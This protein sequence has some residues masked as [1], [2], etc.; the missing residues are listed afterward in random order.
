MKLV[1]VVESYNGEFGII[2]SELGFVDFENKDISFKKDLNVGDVVEFRVEKRF[3]NI[4]LARNI[5]ISELNS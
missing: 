4:M 1:G 2:K 5:I 3:P